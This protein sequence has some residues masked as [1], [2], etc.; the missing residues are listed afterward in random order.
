MPPA[1]LGHLQRR[2]EAVGLGR[3]PARVLAH[4]LGVL[5]LLG[6]EVRRRRGRTAGGG[7]HLPGADEDDEQQQR[8]QR[9]GDAQVIDVEVH[10]RFLCIH[11]TLVPSTCR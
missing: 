6:R 10:V 1:G 5:D 11:L 9:G 2:R 3:G 4:E 8:H 7:G